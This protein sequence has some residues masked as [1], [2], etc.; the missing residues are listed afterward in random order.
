MDDPG[1]LHGPDISEQLQQPRAFGVSGATAPDGVPTI[2][3]TTDPAVH[4][5][6]GAARVWVGPSAESRL[7][8]TVSWGAAGRAMCQ[9]AD[10]I[11]VWGRFGPE[12]EVEIRAP[13]AVRLIV[14][15]PAG[16]VL[17]GPIMVSPDLAPHNLAW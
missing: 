7:Q 14:R 3:F 8:A 6:H 13:G 10:S 11:R 4:G 17:T 15:S 16:A 12:T 9:S 1:P 5:A 2:E